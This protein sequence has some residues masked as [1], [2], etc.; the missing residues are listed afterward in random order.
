MMSIIITLSITILLTSISTHAEL[1]NYHHIAPVAICDLK[2]TI[3]AYEKLDECIHRCSQAIGYGGSA[4]IMLMQDFSSEPGPSVVVCQKIRMKQS[5][6]ETWTFS[7]IVHTPEITVEIPSKE[8]CDRYINQNCSDYKCQSYTPHSLKEEYA[9]A[10]VIHKEETYIVASSHHS[11]LQEIDGKL[12]VIPMFSESKFEVSAG[13]GEDEKGKYYWDKSMTLDKCPLSEGLRMGC[14]IVNLGQGESYICGGG[15]LA[16]DKAGS[17]TMTGACKDIKISP[18]GIVYK[19]VPREPDDNHY[20][21]Q[22]IGMAGFTALTGDAERA[23]ILSQHAMYHVDADLCS[24]QC[25]VSGIELRVARRAQTLLRSGDEYMLVS[26]KGHGYPCS[27]VTHCRLNHPIRVCGSPD[28]V[29]IHCNGRDYYWNPGLNYVTNYDY[30]S[31][32]YTEEAIHIHI[33]NTR[34]NLED[35][36]HI[37]V[38]ENDTYTHKSRSFLLAHASMFKVEDID[39]IRTKWIQEKNSGT[40]YAQLSSSTSNVEQSSIGFQGL[41]SPVK[42]IF[43]RLV[44]ILNHAEAAVISL[45]LTIICMYI[46]Y[47]VWGLKKSKRKRRTAKI[48]SE[49][50]M[51]WI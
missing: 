48:P 33:G 17:K 39:K 25:E 4:S 28:R 16:I 37:E 42:N 23:R 34:Y 26:Q 51:T 46:G 38:P 1:K 29:S 13:Y 22:K 6:E 19:L 44:R 43:N 49:E 36:L 14:D 15:R 2:K 21:N 32:P 3:N 8:E 35:D 27:V 24:L 5:F 40:S 7:T 41:L 18:G 20:K 9:Y 10:S 45:L 31:A 12:M 47:K 30:C 11:T 50:S